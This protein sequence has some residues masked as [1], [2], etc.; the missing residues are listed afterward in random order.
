MLPFDFC[1]KCNQEHI[2]FHIKGEDISSE[3]NPKYS[4][5]KF[6]DSVNKA[7]KFIEEYFPF[8]HKKEISKN[9]N[10]KEKIT[11]AYENCV[12]IN[13]DILQFYQ[14]LID[15]YVKDNYVSNK[16]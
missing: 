8:L 13:K 14:I 11:K 9:I 5:K 6:A 16:N 10:N 2:G 3:I 12:N 4:S 15:N 1:E 7:K